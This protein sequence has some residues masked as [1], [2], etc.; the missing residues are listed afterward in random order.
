MYP[1]R[2]LLAAA[3]IIFATAAIAA[4]P[5]SLRPGQLKALG[6]ETMAAGAAD[7]ARRGRLP[8]SVQVPNAQM[9]VVSAPVGGL[10]EM[11]T[12]APG[13]SVKQGQVVA[14]LSGPEALELQREA[15]QSSA[16]ARLLAQNLKRDEQLFTEGLIA[17]SRLQ[18]TRTAASQAATQARE[19]QQTL[20]QASPTAETMG[21]RVTLVSPIDGVVL[22]QGV[23]LG[24]QVDR[25]AP[26]YRIA[27]LTP[28][29][30]EVQ[31]PLELAMTL[32]VG[33]QIRL[34]DS[35]ITGQLAAIGRTVD[36]SSQTVLLRVEVVAGAE[37]LRPGQIVE[38]ELAAPREK[39][40][41]IPASALARSDGT[42]MVFVQEADNGDEIRF[43]AR[44]V[45]IAGQ[46]GDGIVVD[47]LGAGERIAVKGVSG[48]KAMLGGVGNE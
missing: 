19:R 31:A 48:L 23:Q 38:V 14:R 47:G 18:A 22:E 45:R 3:L 37:M 28:L 6:I 4:P 42:P 16:Q 29:W 40:L 9:R 8:A 15:L 35:D 11:L 39:L 12:V 27:R 17:E 26:I 24:R 1:A 46:S 21:G 5:L 20:A 30:L 25:G 36:P 44:P 2:R 33:A 34:A 10:V 41:R 43:V 13:D 32:R 7:T